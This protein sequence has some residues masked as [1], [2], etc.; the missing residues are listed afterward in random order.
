MLAF[1]E[2]CRKRT[3]LL[4]DFAK[5]SIAYSQGGLE[6]PM[7]SAGIL[8]VLRGIKVGLGSPKLMVWTGRGR[9]EWNVRAW[10]IPHL[11]FPP[12]GLREMKGGGPSA[13]HLEQ[14]KRSINVC[15]YDH[16]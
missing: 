15:C 4:S 6:L 2:L 13:W 11:P 5:S 9:K 3:F 10:N 12:H 7:P 14:G 8:L 1:L 16:V